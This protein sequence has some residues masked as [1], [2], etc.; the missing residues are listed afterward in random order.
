MA[1]PLCAG[2]TLKGAGEALCWGDKDTPTQFLGGLLS[3]QNANSPL[4]HPQPCSV[5][6]AGGDGEVATLPKALG[7]VNLPHAL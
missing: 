2:P 1:S 4:H 6:G 7:L 5:A 3:S